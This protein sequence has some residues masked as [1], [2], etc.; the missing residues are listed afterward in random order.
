MAERPDKLQFD[1]ASDPQRLNLPAAPKKSPPRILTD[2]DKV[3]IAEKPTITPLQIVLAVIEIALNLEIVVMIFVVSYRWNLSGE[4]FS[5]VPEM[6]IPYAVGAVIIFEALYVATLV[7]VSQVGRIAL[8]GGFAL[9]SI[10]AV[11]GQS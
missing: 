2:T 1:E 4:G 8:L 7:S 6:A 11:L 5:S 10:W 3:Q 9:L